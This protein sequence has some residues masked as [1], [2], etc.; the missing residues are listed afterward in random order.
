MKVLLSANALPTHHKIHRKCRSH[1]VHGFA[2]KQQQ[3][4]PCER[5]ALQYS[6]VQRQL[7]SSVHAVLQRLFQFQRGVR[8]Q[9]AL[10][11]DVHDDSV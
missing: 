7:G 5:N 6:E 3:T 2:G 9:S 11:G 10:R 4:Q 8:V 1:L